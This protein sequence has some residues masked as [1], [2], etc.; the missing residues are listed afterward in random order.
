[1]IE[2]QILEATDDS[3]LAD[4]A[5]GLIDRHDQP[6]LAQP[7]YLDD[8]RITRH[9]AAAGCPQVGGDHRQRSVNRLLLDPQLDRCRAGATD[10]V[11]PCLGELAESLHCAD[12][13][14]YRQRRAE[15]PPHAAVGMPGGRRAT[16]VVAHEPS[17]ERHLDAERLGGPSIERA[18][19]HRTGEPFYEVRHEAQHHPGTEQHRHEHA[20]LIR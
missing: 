4:A 19:G 10:G 14:G 5:E 7:A 9:P 16:R 13:E 20:Q 17:D 12:P 3:G 1:M 2:G 11:G 15:H 18:A 8:R 6:A